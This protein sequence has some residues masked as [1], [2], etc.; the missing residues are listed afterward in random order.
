MSKYLTGAVGVLVGFI[1]GVLLAPKSGKETREDLKRRGEA[2]K[3][4][5]MRGYENVSEQVK[6]GSHKL[7]DL[8]EDTVS[9]FKRNSEEAKDEVEKRVRAAK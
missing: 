6:E 1:A 7:K 2:M 8:A 5:S 9:H 3:D 4:A